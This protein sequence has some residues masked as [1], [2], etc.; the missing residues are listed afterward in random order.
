MPK[1][2]AA[3]MRIKPGLRTYLGNVPADVQ[4]A[5]ALPTLDSSPTLTGDFDHMH[6]FTTSRADLEQ[7]FPQ[8]KQHLRSTGAL[9]ISWPKG[10]QQGTDLTLPAVIQVGYRFGLVESVCLSVDAVWSALKF[11]HPKAGKE[12]HNSHATLQR[13]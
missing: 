8:L 11:T 1:T 9:W 2:V 10:R 4:A 13:T 7:A 12:Y 3:K 5:M 6:Y